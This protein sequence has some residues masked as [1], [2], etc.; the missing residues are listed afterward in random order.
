METGQ[1]SCAGHGRLA[2]EAWSGTPGGTLPSC[3]QAHGVTR[4]AKQR[5]CVQTES[6]ADSGFPP[7]PPGR[8]SC[9]APYRGR[10]G[11]HPGGLSADFRETRVKGEDSELGCTS[12]LCGSWPVTLGSP[13]LQEPRFACVG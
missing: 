2:R 12:R 7:L 11:D 8:G 3:A 1:D 6:R 9:H 13:P 5:S 10:R 4:P